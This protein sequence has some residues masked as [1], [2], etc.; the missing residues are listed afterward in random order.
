MPVFTCE[1]CEQP[2]QGYACHRARGESKFCSRAC[3]VAAKSPVL[4]IEQLKAESP[5]GA[6]W[7]WPRGRSAGGYGSLGRRGK[8]NLAHRYAYEALVGPVPDGLVLD[9]LCRNRAC[10]NPAHLEPVTNLENIRRGVLAKTHCP[11]GH[12]YE[13]ENL[14]IYGGRRK[15]A[16]CIRKSNCISSSKRRSQKKALV[17]REVQHADL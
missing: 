17:D 8:S 16:T 14:R 10:V 15:C 9:H 2:F 3:F 1:I 11:Q 6:C 4:V 7:S 12:P 5:A 13:G